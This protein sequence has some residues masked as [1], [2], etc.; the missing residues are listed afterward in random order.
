MA[1]MRPIQSPLLVG[2]DELLQLAERRIEEAAAGRGHMLLVAGEAGVGKTRL[3]HS[4]E[5]RAEARGFRI[6]QG[7]LSPNDSEVPL[8]SIRDLARTMTQIQAFGGLGAKVL[9]HER[10]GGVGDGLARRQLLVHAIADLLLDA[11][12]TPTL[13]AFDDLQW[14]D[15][16][17]LEVIRELARR[18]RDLPLLLVG[19][20]RVGELPAG[21]LHRE[22]RARLL[23]QRMA[24][25]IRLERLTYEETSLVTTLILGTGLPA[26]REVVA[27]VYERTNGIPLHIEELLAALRDAGA[28]DARTIR[29][30]HVPDTIEDAVLA[31]YERLSSEAKTVARA[32]AVIG[33]CFVPE[34]LAGIVDRP[35]AELDAPL[36]ELVSQAFLYP[37]SHLDRG[38]YDFR[39]QLLRDALYGAVQTG[40][41]RRLHARAAEFG[42]I[43]DGASE[44]HASVHFERAGLRSQAYRAALTGARAASEVS[45]RREA[46][47]LYGRAVRN[48]PPDLPPADVAL[49]YLAFADAAGAVDD[50]AII[51][52]AGERAREAFLAAGDPLHAAEMLLVRANADMRMAEPLAQRIAITEQAL[53]ELEALPPGDERSLIECDVYIYR[54]I[55]ALDEPRSDAAAEWFRLARAALDRVDAGFSAQLENV[56]A[57]RA[58]IPAY[59]AE[60]EFWEANL[61]VLQGDVDAGLAATM[62]VARRARDARFEATSVSAFRNT[63]VLGVRVMDYGF[64]RVGLEEGL[65]YADEIE[66]SFCRHIMGA[67]S[68]QILWADG[69]WDEARAAAEIEL[70]EPGSRR[71]TLCALD[72]LGYV[73]MGRGDGDRAR[74]VLEESLA[75]GVASGST[76]LIMPPR[77]GLAELAL[78]A[79]DADRAFALCRAAA[80]LAE[81]SG[82]RAL[83][84]PF[85]VTGARAALAARRPDEADRWLERMSQLLAGWERQARPALDHAEGLIRTANGSTVVARTALEA[86]ISGWDGIGR[87]W[88]GQ[89]ARLD[90]AACLL[91]SNRDAEAIAVLRDAGERADALASAPLRRRADDLMAIARSRGAEEEPWR[92]LT[93]REFEVARL[94]AD[95]LTNGAIGE[96]LG[97][98]PRTVGAHVEHIL[99]KLGFTRRTEIAAW[100]AAMAVTA[101]SVAG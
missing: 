86:A 8:A 3:V 101:G 53:T 18:S 85:V 93:G 16:L 100:V 9:A 27:A 7:D 69:R 83:M 64:A 89:W 58:D 24:E 5:R 40:E 65:R 6:A 46:F 49:L 44:I 14:A 59:R 55:W 82:E 45:S 92:P 26:S 1:T 31:R 91:R 79:G 42:G 90:L 12:D 36:E 22:W 75:S 78:L 76:A 30:A 51:R 47:E 37:F 25:E 61:A 38:Y 66:Q 57:Y 88:E 50:S 33:R 48:A 20:Y 87:T 4:I 39:H 77:W 62:A 41:L 70:V 52:S 73:A 13:L 15:E 28:V 98:S 95:G 94:V 43:L 74:A 99:A 81:E 68:A 11:I 71:G 32:G 60:I 54:A 96:Q 67:V 23:S 80:E 34:V 17:S 97:L 35:I 10:S 19:G 21:S 72:A 2:R 63:A 84:V 29:D 56:E